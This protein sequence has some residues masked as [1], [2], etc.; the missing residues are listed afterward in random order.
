M[1]NTAHT[2]PPQADQLLTKV[3]AALSHLDYA[4]MRH[5]R[6][7]HTS[8]INDINALMYQGLSHAQHP[9]LGHVMVKWG[10]QNDKDHN[11]GS[12]FT[13]DGILM[14]HIG[15]NQLVPPLL[16]QYDLPL[17]LDNQTLTL[18]AIVMPYYPNGSLAQYL[19]QPLSHTQKRNA[20][21]QAAQL[22]ADVHQC[23]WLHNDIK[24]SNVL[25]HEQQLLLTDF[26]LASKI[27]DKTLSDMTCSKA[28]AGT[29]AYLAPERW[30]GAGATVQSD[31]YAFGVMMVEILIGARPFKITAQSGEPLMDWATQH[32]QQPVPNLPSEYRHYQR[33]VN[34]ALAK[35]VE[36]RYQSMEAVLM[37]LADL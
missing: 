30:N 17:V 4:D 14:A 3:T 7:S 13:H 9:R 18:H 15:A 16:S 26:A 1:K 8:H 32:C 6:I 19:N 31:V 34:K 21:I 10:L 5:Q 20:L 29:P 28:I 25:R 27:S 33:I 12:T 22:I 23:G 37:G 11:N 35:R 36:K 2:L 24:P